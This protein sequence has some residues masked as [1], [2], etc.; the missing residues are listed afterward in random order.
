MTVPIRQY[1]ISGA[2][3]PPIDRGNAGSESVVLQLRPPW[4]EPPDNATEFTL[5]FS[6]NAAGGSVLT[7]LFTLDANQNPVR[8][9]AAIQLPN[10]SQARINAVAIGGD[11][12]A[13]AGAPVL[14]FS[15]RTDRT[16]QSVL[17][18][19][20][21]VGLPGRGGI[22]SVGFEPFTRILTE[23][24]FVGGF[25]INSSGGPLYAEMIITGWYW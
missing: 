25:V 9:S 3:F 15:I 10:T 12:G 11:T 14:L 6:A 23:G 8:P 7:P 1:D 22:V 4:F 16:G 21:G 19:W 5:S 2:A 20:E 18:G 13:V 17:P 24:A